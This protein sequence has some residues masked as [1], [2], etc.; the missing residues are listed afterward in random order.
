MGIWEVLSTT[1]LL[2]VSSNSTPLYSYDY[3]FFDNDRKVSL[4]SGT[5]F[6]RPSVPEI[7]A[8]GLTSYGDFDF[9]WSF[10]SPFISEKYYRSS[11]FG[12]EVIYSYDLNRNLSLLTSIEFSS[13][14]EEK[15]SPCLDDFGRK[16]HCYYGT[17][18]NQLLYLSSFDQI[19][20]SL[21]RESRTLKVTSIDFVLQFSF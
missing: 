15:I 10:T 18:P 2:M 7:S 1:T 12:L 13:F 11:F 16:F 4:A 3:F 8:S 19:E 5:H 14:G 6:Y 9:L 17:Q 20:K 21:Y